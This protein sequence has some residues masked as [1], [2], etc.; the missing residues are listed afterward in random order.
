MS[1]GRIRARL[2]AVWIVL[3]A[4]I[5]AIIVIERNDLMRTLK[6]KDDGHGHWTGETHWLLPAPIEQLGAI[7]IAHAGALHRFE[8][9]ASGA[10]FYHGA[11]TGQEGAHAH[12]ADPAVSQKIDHALAGFGRARIERT[13]ALDFGAVGVDPV[14]RELLPDPEVRDY[15]VTVPSII[16]L[17]Y[18]PGGA[19]PL[20]QYAVGDVAPDGLSRYV[21]PVGSPTVVTIANYQITNLLNLVAEMSNTP[22]A[23]ATARSAP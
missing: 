1:T 16:V 6:A 17:V 23:G 14:Q 4:L 13:F 15:G 18:A 12:R 9:D 8:R 19:Q 20:V 2:L 3:V 10:W 21:L 11:H 22:V 7:E 5:A